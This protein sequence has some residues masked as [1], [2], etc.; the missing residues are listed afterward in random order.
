MRAVSAKTVLYYVSE[1]GARPAHDWFVSL[2]TAQAEKVD[3]AVRRMELGNL[4]D[5]K[6][7]G[8]GVLERRIFGTPPLRL[9]FGLDG[10]NLVIL[11][12]GGS[13]SGQQGDITQAQI[14]WAD[15]KA[16]KKPVKS[17]S[18]VVKAGKKPK[19]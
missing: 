9:Y 17:K 15:Y 16:R 2:D 12:A 14:Y 1:G 6:A 13:K 7:V 5:Y 10:K 19:K 3:D 8:D 11:L 18:G 4:G